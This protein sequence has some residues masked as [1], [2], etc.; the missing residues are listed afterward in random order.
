MPLL[1]ADDL[2]KSFPGRR[3]TWRTDSEP[4]QAVRGVSLSVSAGETLAIVGETGSGKTTLGR[5]LLRLIT[6][7]RGQISFDGTEL[8]SLSSRDLRL[9]R[10]EMQ[11][12]F[13]NPFSALDPRLRVG[14]QVSEPLLVHRLVTDK[15]RRRQRAL[16]LFERVGLEAA[17]MNRLPRELS[18]GQLQRVGIA[19]AL[20]TTPR[21]LVCDEPVAALDMSSRA[22]IMNLLNQLQDEHGL[23]YVFITHD[24]SVLGASADKVAVMFEGTIVEFGSAHQILSEPRH[25][26]TQM[27]LRSVPKLDPSERSILGAARIETPAPDPEVPVKSR[28]RVEGCPFAK[29]CP[30]VVEQCKTER[31]VLRITNGAAVACHLAHETNREIPS[32]AR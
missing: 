24:L 26:Y 23:A 7:D 11:M 25:P 21:L 30:L 2:W 28:S 10:R 27:L 32:R 8:S 9:L 16:E 29:R 6:P 22:H 3:T 4:I 1:R 20:A 13:Q 12:I 31:P 19:R 15:S 18:G 17:H 14:D 5:L